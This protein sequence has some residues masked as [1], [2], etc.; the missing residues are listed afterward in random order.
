MTTLKVYSIRTKRDK[1]DIEI[2][3][4]HDIVLC[5]ANKYNK[6]SQFCSKYK[7]SRVII[8]EADTINLPNSTAISCHFLWF[9]TTTFERL[10]EILIQ[11][12]SSDLDIDKMVKLYGEGMQLSKSCK[13]V[14][15]QA[16]HI[17]SNE[18]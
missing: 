8:D 13:D 17:G 14:I 5:N 7:W 9:I 11:L 2:F 15:E 16:E 10:E 4:N 6:L 12:E 18:G 3:K 1:M